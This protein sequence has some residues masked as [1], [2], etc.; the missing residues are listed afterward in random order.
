MMRTVDPINIGEKFQSAMEK[1]RREGVCFW[2]VRLRCSPLSVHE[3]VCNDAPEDTVLK[4]LVEQYLGPL[5]SSIL[6]EFV[7]AR[8]RRQDSGR[9][10]AYRLASGV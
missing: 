9:R 7:R 3:S 5:G 4:R 6:C 10:E 1:F 8:S 2:L